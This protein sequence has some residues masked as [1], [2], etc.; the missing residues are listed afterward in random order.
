MG[1][2]GGKDTTVSDLLD[3]DYSYED[4][5]FNENTSREDKD[6]SPPLDINVSSSESKLMLRY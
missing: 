2:K 1:E 3:S 6:E 5:S 4:S